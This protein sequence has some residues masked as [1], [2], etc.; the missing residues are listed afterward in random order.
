MVGQVNATGRSRSVDGGQRGSRLPHP[1]FALCLLPLAFFLLLA[2]GEHARVATPLGEDGVDALLQRAAQSALGGRDG[3]VLVLDAQ[4]G[5]V[6]AAVNQHAAFEEATPPGSAIKPFTM[7]TAL[8]AGTLEEATRLTCRRRYK[9]DGFK[10]NCAHPRYA[11]P[12]GPAQALA[13]SCNYFF[14]NT[15]RALDPDAFARTLSSFG[16]G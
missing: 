1:T 13:N 15:A 14:A 12:F 4:T 5:R 16:F 11:T 3:V 9:E 10:I 8:R 2:R 6:R 7:L